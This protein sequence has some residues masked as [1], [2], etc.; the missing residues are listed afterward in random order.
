LDYALGQPSGLESM[1]LAST[2]ASVP[3]FAAETRRLKE[4][5]PAEVQRTID[6]HEAAGTTDDQAYG[7]A[8]MAYY[9]RWICR[10]DLPW[11]DHVMRSANNISEDVYA[12]MQGPEWNV[13]GNLKDWDVTERLGELALPALVTSGR[14]DEMTEAVVRPL[15]AGIRGAEWVVFENSAHFAPVEEP[16]RYRDV[17]TTFLDRVEANPPDLADAA[18][19]STDPP[20]PQADRHTAN[21]V[22]AWAVLPRRSQ[23]SC[24]STARGCPRWDAS[25]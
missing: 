15:V 8:A 21:S 3:A 10:L 11:P 1:V 4:S 12:T 7:E 6:A 19:S 18:E 20:A 14:H 13:T 22:D 23:L 24:G 16:D 17:L 5:L 2:S 25:R 9:T